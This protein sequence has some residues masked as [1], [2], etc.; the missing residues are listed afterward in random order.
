MKIRKIPALLCAAAIL[1]TSVLPVQAAPEAAL[2]YSAVFDAEY[3]YNTYPDLQQR[4]GNDPSALLQHFIKRGM[5]EGRS[6]NASFQVKAYMLNNLDL[7]AAYGAS[8]LTKYYIHYISFGQAEKR[9]AVYQQGMQPAENTLASYSTLY[10]TTEDRAVNVEQAAARINGLTVAP[11][12]QFSFSDSVGSRTLANGYVVAPSFAG[13]TVVSSVG[14]GICQVSST[15]YVV[16]LLSLITPDERYPH[17]LP[18]YYVPQ[19][20]D[21]AIAAGYKDLTFTNPYDFNIE[22][23]T[24]CQNGVLTVSLV[25]QPL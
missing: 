20:L 11:G 6:G 16:M 18:V 8:D 25:R 19:G 21:S 23:Q 14:G 10:D 5:K 3:Y 17:S 1:F 4:I 2:D 24:A 13:G 7:V 9:S 15:L 12:E 22:I